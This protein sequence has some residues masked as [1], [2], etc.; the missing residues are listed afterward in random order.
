MERRTSS[1]RLPRQM[2]LAMLGLLRFDPKV[3]LTFA[4]PLQELQAQ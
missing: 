3:Y 2:P 1:A 4:Q